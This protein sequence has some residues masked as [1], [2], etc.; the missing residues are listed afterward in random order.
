MARIAMLILT[1]TLA[2]VSQGAMA[3]EP[4]Q[5]RVACR[6]VATLAGSIMQARQRDV[7]MDEVTAATEDLPKETLSLARSMVTDAY[8]QPRHADDAARK[9]AI[10]DFEAD[11]YSSCYGQ[12][13][14]Q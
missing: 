5:T 13:T 8:V 10:E 11:Y 2:G 6:N 4:D 12:L 1:V 14:Q 9:K 3:A 7:P